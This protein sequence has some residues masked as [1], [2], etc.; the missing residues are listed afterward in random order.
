[1][2]VAGPLGT[3]L[4]LAQRKRASPRGDTRG[5]RPRLEGKEKTLLSSRVAT[6]MSWSPLSTCEVPVGL[7]SLGEWAKLAEKAGPLWLWV[8][9]GGG[10][11]GL[12]LGSHRAR[13]LLLSPRQQLLWVPHWASQS[14]VIMEASPPLA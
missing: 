13:L 5:V 6:G 7:R 2:E 10:L 14:S 9:Q 11:L 3:P 1:M 12:R 8:H 4:G